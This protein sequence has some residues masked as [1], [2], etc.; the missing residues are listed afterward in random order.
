MVIRAPM[1]GTS[2]VQPRAFEYRRGLRVWERDASSQA[3]RP[4]L[5]ADGLTEVIES[6]LLEYDGGFV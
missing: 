2:I 4:L 6:P 3:S 5:A 1:A